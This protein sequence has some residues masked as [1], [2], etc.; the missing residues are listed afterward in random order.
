MLKYIIYHIYCCL[1]ICFKEIKKNYDQAFET[2]FKKVHARS[3]NKKKTQLKKN[4]NY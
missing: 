2:M 3:R 4:F 1:I